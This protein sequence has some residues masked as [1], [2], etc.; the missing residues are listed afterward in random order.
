[1]TPE[2][3][4]ASLNLARAWTLL[5]RVYEDVAATGR[6]LHRNEPQQQ[7]EL[8]PSLIAASRPS[9]R[10]APGGETPSPAPAPVEEGKGG[11]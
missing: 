11:G 6:W 7:A 9:P 4:A 8:F 2:A 3:K 1:M 5:H 10:R